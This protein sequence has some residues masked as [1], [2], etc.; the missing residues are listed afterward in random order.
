MLYKS[1]HIIT[2]VSANLVCKLLGQPSISNLETQLHDKHIQIQQLEEQ[3]RALYRVISKIR[4]SLE[5]E[6]IFRT[7]TKETCKLLRVERIAVYRFYENWGGEFVSDFEFAE[8]GWDDVEKL[9]KNTVWSDSY[10]QEHQGGRYR[11]NE[12]LV[13]SDVYVAG[14]SQCHLEILEQF[15][16][17]AYATAPIF[18]GKKLWGVLAAYQHSQPHEWKQLEIQFLSQIAIQLGFAVKQA[19]F[20][21]QAEQK[22][23]ELY[24]ANQQQDILFNLV[25]EIRESLN[26]DILFKTTVREIR[27]ALR[28]DRVSIFRFDLKSNYTSGQFVSENVLPDYDSTIAIKVKD[29][30]FGEKYAVA[31]QQGRM[32][33]LSDVHQAGLKDCHL[34]LLEQFQIKAQIIAPLMKGKILWGLLCVQQCRCSRE[35]ETSEIQFI[36]QLAA[37]FNVALEHSELLEQSRSQANQLAQTNHAL[38]L[39][40]SQLEKISKLDALTQIANRHCFDEFLEQEWN[41]LKL[42]ENYLSLIMFDIDYFKDYNDSYGHL[43]GDECLIQVARAAQS[44]LK[45]PTDLLARYGGEEFIVILPNTNESGAIK[46]TKLIQKSI[47]ELKIAHKKKDNFQ[48]FVTVSLGVAIQRPTDKSSAQDLIN[49]ADKALYKAKDQGRN[50]WV[51][52][53]K[54]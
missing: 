53:A 21:A 16:I 19:E 38:E 50:R 13:A 24:K 23:A 4:A 45:R 31:Y 40:N 52:A 41:R 20:L 22:A 6:T 5:L 49:A 44:V 42:S 12:T 1:L 9:G 34:Q 51:C 29:H 3:E 47:Q 26:L 43:A 2:K 37:Q 32:Q 30:C 33:I 27:K 10:L 17:R 46:V 7:A 28:S 54:L 48:Y 8:T 14:L 25:A 39:A 15:H 36:R 11:N 35:W 18:V